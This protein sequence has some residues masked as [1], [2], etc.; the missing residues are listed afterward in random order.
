MGKLFAVVGRGLWDLTTNNAG[1]IIV[2]LGG[3]GLMIYLAS[4]T[5][6]MRGAGPFGWVAG[7]VC[8]ALLAALAYAALT[9]AKVKRGVY[10]LAKVKIDSGKVNV[11]APTHEHERLNAVDFYSPDYHPIENVRFTD[12]DLLGPASVYFMGGTFN[13]VKFYD[14]EIVIVRDDRPVR[15]VTA[16]ASPWF[17]RGRFYR[18]TMMMNIKQ[19]KALPEEM[20]KGVTVIS[21]GR[22]GDL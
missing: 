19:Y 20:R 7:A 13:A 4:I 17:L 22:V 12:C 6:W 2:W 15:G 11:L 18:L 3:T 5:E 9:Y 16:F 14:C 1:T 8:V 10:R 21:D